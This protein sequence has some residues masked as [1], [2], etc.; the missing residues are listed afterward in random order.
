MGKTFIIQNAMETKISSIL[1][2][3]LY[4][5]KF[6]MIPTLDHKMCQILL[7]NFLSSLLMLAVRTAT[8]WILRIFEFLH[9]FCCQV[10][11]WTVHK[12]LQG[13]KLDKKLC[14]MIHMDL[15]VTIMIK[16]CFYSISR[17]LSLL[18]FS[19][20]SASWRWIIGK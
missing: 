14:S 3:F 7:H 15:N 8:C 12:K 9:Y 20:G 13:S 5:S 19:L 2:L 10:K 16:L 6:A 1:I 18:V 17:Y 4:F 11:F